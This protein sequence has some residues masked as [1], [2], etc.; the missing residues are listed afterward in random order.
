MNAKNTL[1]SLRLAS[2]DF[3]AISSK[4]SSMTH[5]N[6]AMPS[7]AYKGAESAARCNCSGCTS[8]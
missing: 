2:S 5:I 4:L 7:N 3:E 8:W 1:D 6:P